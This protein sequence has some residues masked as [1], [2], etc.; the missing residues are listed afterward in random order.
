V[1]I[2][3]SNKVNE[4]NPKLNGIT[5]GLGIFNQGFLEKQNTSKEY[6]K[7]VTEQEP[8]TTYLDA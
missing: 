8:L 6:E 2:L 3:N 5:I 1:F 4:S 7:T